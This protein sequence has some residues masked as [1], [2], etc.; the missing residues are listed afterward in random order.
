[1]VQ[2]GHYDFV[3][4]LALVLCA[5][6]VA[7]VIFKRLRQPVVVG[8]LLAGLAIGPHEPLRLI[9]NVATL[10]G[11][12][13]LGVI[14]VMFSLGLEFNFKRLA[15]VLPT[16][17]VAALLEVSFVAWCGYIATQWLGWSVSESV[18]S[19][20]IVAISSTTIVVKA[21]GEAG[22]KARFAELVFGILVVE[23]VVAIVLLATLATP[24]GTGPSAFAIGRTL[25]RLAAFLALLLVAGMFVIPRL[26]RMI[27]RI[28]HDE[29]LLIASVG[30]CFAIAMVA[31]DLGFSAALGAFAAGI[32]V[33]ESGEGHQVEHL[34][35]S[36]RDVFAAIFFV[37]VGM[38][39]DPVQ[40]VHH[41]YAVA[42]L[43]VVVIV[44][45]FAGV[46]GGSFL[47][48]GSIDT[49]V[50]AGLSLGQIGEVSFIIAASGV[51][52][53]EIRSFLYTV[54]IA[55][56]GITTLITPLTIRMSPAV[57]AACDRYLPRPLQMFADF[58]GAWLE[59]MRGGNPATARSPIMCRIGWIVLDAVLL[60][61]IV[62]GA[63]VELPGLIE[64]MR[65][66][67]V[68]PYFVARWI[69]IAATV[70]LALPF[71]LGIIRSAHRLAEMLAR[72]ALPPP[73]DHGLDLGIAP[74]R[75]L[76]AAVQLAIVVLVGLPLLLITEPFL[77]DLPDFAVMAGPALIMG[78][79]FWRSA[80][81]F[82]G[83]V[84]AGTEMIIEA[85][86][87]QSRAHSHLSLAGVEQLFPG[88][89]KLVP[90]KLEP[91]SVAVG[92]TLAG[93][94]LRVATG[95]TVLAILRDGTNTVAPAAQEQLRSG[96]LI[97]LAGSD[98]AVRAAA[99][100]L[101]RT[102]PEAAVQRFAGD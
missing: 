14:L 31:R 46:A 81:G 74:R 97:A 86:T 78:M 33:S 72:H 30:L 67:A 18:F 80:T 71:F 25:E 57:A 26:I 73:P 95:A 35:A 13:D 20:A 11:L 53:G 40:I 92:A 3:A 63:S 50:R 1:M 62:I 56:C 66:F 52:N 49:S 98:A 12:A 27:V 91:D 5:A 102:T 55:V 9:T 61:A 85:L 68:S 19:A 82:L 41:W 87:A 48:S 37:A 59:R 21:F 79:I 8:Y 44:G 90:V 76:I 75:L 88:V 28:R 24:L 7:A 100:M 15:R 94:N 16:A 17:G 29:T 36:V 99:A 45:K 10:H 69:V 64:R 89:G 60:A 77:P 34:I 93:L 42:L 54:A 51:A 39:I 4:A 65:R 58:Y 6:A 70:L 83:H 96:D 2:A 47:I 32:L 22:I 38:M 84:S 101:T 43:V 23:D